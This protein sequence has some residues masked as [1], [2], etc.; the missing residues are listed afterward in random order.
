ML[1][2][3][4]DMSRSL[5]YSAIRGDGSAALGNAIVRL[6]SRRK[7]MTEEQIIRWFLGTREVYVVTALQA[8]VD[9]NRVTIDFGPRGGI[10]YSVKEAQ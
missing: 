2:S 3:R 1:A 5:D 4:R 9:D 7:S 6:L 10:R 8:A